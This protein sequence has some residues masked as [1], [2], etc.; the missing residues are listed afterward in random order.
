MIGC[1]RSGIRDGILLTGS[2]LTQLCQ[3]S[4]FF[5]RIWFQ[6][7][8]NSFNFCF[9]CHAETGYIFIAFQRFS[10]QA[11]FQPWISAQVR[12]AGAARFALCAGLCLCAGCSCG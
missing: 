4:S 5:D 10:R 11:I 6:H 2:K 12:A 3:G 1:S 7:N 9:H 8:F